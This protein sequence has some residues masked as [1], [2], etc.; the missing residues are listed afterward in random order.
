MP[1]RSNSK[2]KTARRHHRCS[3]HLAGK[4]NG[5]GERVR[6]LRKKAGFT[7]EVLAARCSIQGWNIDRQIVAHIE[8]SLREVS[9]LELRVLCCVFKTTPNDL[10]GYA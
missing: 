3:F 2:P 9:D 1:E 7:Q 6:T 4:R 8:G 5:I 10:M